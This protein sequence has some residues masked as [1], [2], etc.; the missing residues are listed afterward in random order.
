MK[1]QIYERFDI[2]EPNNS[3][4]TS[5]TFHIPIT[6]DTP[7]ADFKA[8][9]YGYEMANLPSSLNTKISKISTGAIPT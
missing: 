5:P 2:I 3:V 9:P 1:P 4:K 7:N 6:Q 8:V